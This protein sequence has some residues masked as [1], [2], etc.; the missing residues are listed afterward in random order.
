MWINL[1][2]GG[3]FMGAFVTCSYMAGCSECYLLEYSSEEKEHNE[4]SDA[5]QQVLLFQLCFQPSVS[6]PSHKNSC[7]IKEQAG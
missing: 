5:G 6:V 3:R 2:D 1:S 7:N 4:I